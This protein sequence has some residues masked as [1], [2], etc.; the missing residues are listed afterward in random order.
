MLYVAKVVNRLAS[1]H[2]KSA[3]LGLLAGIVYSYSI[4]ITF[5]TQRMSRPCDWFVNVVFWGLCTTSVRA[6]FRLN[7]Y[8]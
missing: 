7:G 4:V 8:I 1:A 6:A 5:V 3:H 2:T